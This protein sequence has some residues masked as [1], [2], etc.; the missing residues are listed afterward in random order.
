MSV[1]TPRHYPFDVGKHILD[2][3]G[4]LRLVK[5]SIGD[6]FM[7]SPKLFVPIIIFLLLLAACNASGSE[8]YLVD[9]IDSASAA[10]DSEDNARAQQR[11]RVLG[12]SRSRGC[13]THGG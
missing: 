1:I 3:G 10:A 2:S 5:E 8:E 4:T 9:T 13:G 12:N 6:Q 11:R 7:K